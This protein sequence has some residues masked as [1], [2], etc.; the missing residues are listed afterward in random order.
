[1]LDKSDTVEISVK[2]AGIGIDKKYLNNIFGRF[3]QVDKSLT[4]N[5]EGCGIGLS[6]VKSI[7]EMHGGKITVDSE[8]GVGS[9]FKIEL[10]VK[11]TENVK[12]IKQNKIMNN[13]IDM[14]NVEF[15]D[16]YSI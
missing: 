15:S 10:P 8:V 9:V 2:D 4:R 7:V 1:M 13:K 3:Q 16:I 11:T 12:V 6:L 5:A 14:I